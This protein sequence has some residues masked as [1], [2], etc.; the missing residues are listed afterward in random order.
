ML[1]PCEDFALRSACQ[2]R[3]PRPVGRYESLPCDIETCMLAILEQELGLQRSIES[4]KHEVRG[5]CDYT[6]T[7]VFRAVDKYN[8]GAITMNNLRNFLA[9]QGAY[10]C[11]QELVPIIRRIDTDADG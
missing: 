8:D 4:L 10:L 5:M 11:E 3:H 2:E 7:A 1:L 6:A 9:A